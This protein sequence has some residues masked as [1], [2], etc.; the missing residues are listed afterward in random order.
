MLALAG[1]TDLLLELYDTLIVVADGIP[2]NT[3]LWMIP[4]SRTSLKPS[5]LVITILELFVST[6]LTLRIGK[7]YSNPRVMDFHALNKPEDDMYDR[8][9]TPRMPW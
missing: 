4:I 3:S 8:G 5:G 1:T 6:V 7:D 2:L 9:K